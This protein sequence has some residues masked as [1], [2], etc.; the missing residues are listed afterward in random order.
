M[1]PVEEV[2]EAVAMLPRIITKQGTMRMNAKVVEQAQ[3]SRW[4]FVLT[5]PSV[6]LIHWK[7]HL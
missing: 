2:I 5:K 7:F 6:E 4:E 1:F 3:S